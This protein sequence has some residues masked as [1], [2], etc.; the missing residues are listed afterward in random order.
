MAGSEPWITLRRDAEHSTKLLSDPALDVFVAHVGGDLAGLIALDMRGSFAGYIRVLI[1][2]SAHRSQGIG[3]QL[4]QFAEERVFR[5]SPNVF[6]LVSSFNPR[7]QQFYQRLG[8]QRIGELKDYVI[9]GAT[10]ILMRKTIGPRTGFQPR[11]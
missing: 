5:E 10:E 7:A 3:A 6:L 8:Y 1:V 9:A 4:M 2:A 11:Q